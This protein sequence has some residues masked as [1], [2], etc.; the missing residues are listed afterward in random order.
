VENKPSFWTTL[1]GI[2]TGII[3]LITALVGLYSALHQ[4]PSADGGP[5]P[6]P[7][8]E[9]SRLVGRWRG[10]AFLPDSLQLYGEIFLEDSFEFHSTAQTPQGTIPAGTGTWQYDAAAQTLTL[11]GSNLLNGG[12]RLRCTYKSLSPQADSL[13]GTCSDDTR[14]NWTSEMT[15][16]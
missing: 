6:A 7:R 14:L 5:P 1:P 9:A 3:T 8:H 11:N 12:V 13:R 16:Q 10:T 15:R 4:K 2:L